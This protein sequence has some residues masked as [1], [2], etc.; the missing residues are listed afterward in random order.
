[1]TNPRG[2]TFPEGDI[3]IN[4]DFFVLTVCKVALLSIP[5][6][7]PDVIGYVASLYVY[8]FFHDWFR[9]RLWPLTGY[10]SLGVP[11]EGGE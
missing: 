3:M 8:Y 10:S 5:K 9:R 6:V 7:C 1:M 2:Y 11:M 4:E